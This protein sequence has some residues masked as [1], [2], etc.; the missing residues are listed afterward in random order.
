MSKVSHKSYNNQILFCL[1]I[2][3]FGYTSSHLFYL[4]TS[5]CFFVQFWYSY[6]HAGIIKSIWWSQGQTQLVVEGMDAFNNPKLMQ[7]WTFRFSQSEVEKVLVQNEAEKIYRALGLFS[8]ILEDQWPPNPPRL[9]NWLQDHPDKLRDHLGLVQGWESECWGVP[10]IPSLSKAKS[11]QMS[12]SCFLIAMK[13]VF[14]ILK[15]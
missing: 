12:L 8:D 7:I 6:G 14:K 4:L 5:L 13:F 2:G 9:P 15:V 10:G 3:T 1:N 11:Y